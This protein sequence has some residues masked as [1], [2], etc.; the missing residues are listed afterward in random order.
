LRRAGAQPRWPASPFTLGVASGYPTPS[1]VVLW[2]R[3]A[4]A[5][6]Q[7]GGGM[8]PEVVPVDWEV[9]T[10]ERMGHVVQRGTAYA[11]PEW[12]HAVHVE[13]NRLRP[14]H[15]YWYRFRA[16]GE[17]S[18]VGRTRTAPPAAGAVDRL[19]FAF[20]SCQQYEHGFYAAHHRMLADDLDLVVFLGDYIYEST[21]GRDHVRH[22]G[23]PEPHTLDDYRA[24]HALYKSDADLQAMHAACPWLVTWDDHEVSNDYA[25]DRSQH[26]HPRQWFL[27]RRA[28]AYQAYY[29]HM[30]LPR[31]MVPLGP[32]ARIFHRVAF[33]TLVEFHVTDNRQFR[34]HQP[35]VAPGRGGATVAEDCEARLDPALTMLGEVQE[36][37]L[38]MGLDRSRCRWN[39]IAQQSIMAQVDRKPGPGRQFWTDSWDGYPVARRRLLEFLGARRPGNPVVIGGDVHAFWVTDLKPDFDAAASPVVATE[40]VGTSI[41]SQGFRQEVLDALRADNPH[42]RFVDGTRRGYVRVDLTPQR[43]QADL[44]AM[45]TVTDPRG[46]CDTLATFVVEDGNP[47]AVRA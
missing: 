46:E 18:A 34:S 29:E 24:R 21:W 26:A 16:G 5:P 7:P 6:L 37:W 9:A 15:W 23:T 1:S 41:T 43:L 17:V 40:L 31:H 4:P 44:R 3:L 20:A 12:A 13:V 45:R 10:D 32:H 33:G 8:A 27:A 2:T 35:C 39:V 25:D 30:P 36:R 22:H 19:R 14:G 38:Q 47:G 28:A 11:S 42:V